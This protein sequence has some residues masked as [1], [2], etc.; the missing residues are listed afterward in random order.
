MVTRRDRTLLLMLMFQAVF[1]TAAAS[2]HLGQLLPPWGI[3]LVGLLSSMISAA[4]GVYVVMT[5]E[6]IP[7]VPTGL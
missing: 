3:A 2:A 4:T 1:N 5:Q 7:R 6:P